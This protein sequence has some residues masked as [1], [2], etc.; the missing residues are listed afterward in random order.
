MKITFDPP[1][2]DW[3][4]RVRGLDFADAEAVFAG[5]TITIEDKRF[6]YPER[7]FITFGL[8]GD[9]MGVV[10]W[11]PD[12]ELDDEDGRR[13][14]SMRKANAREQARYLQRLGEGGRYH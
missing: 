9:R 1:N 2:R 5:V 4:L 7:R 12:P 6:V 11:T 8:F 13:V 14:I 10:V 3:T